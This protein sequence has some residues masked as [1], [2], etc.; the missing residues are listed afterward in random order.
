[1]E[2]MVVIP[3]KPYE[4]WISMCDPKRPE[5]LWLKNGIIA[6]SRYGRREVQIPCNAK[7]E[8]EIMEY[9]ARACPEVVPL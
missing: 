8:K 1:M 4:A 3:I 9:A 2:I 5:Y 7:R 6:R